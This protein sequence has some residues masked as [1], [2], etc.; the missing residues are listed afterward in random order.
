MEQKW[1]WEKEKVRVE[2]TEESEGRAACGLGILYKR[3]INK[4]KE[5]K[6]KVIWLLPL[7]AVSLLKVL[8]KIEMGNS[9]PFSPILI[10]HSYTKDH[11][12]GFHFQRSVYKSFPQVV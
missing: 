5:K 1:K 11:K 7:Q 10:K 4:E 8:V 12:C 9:E 2:R 6:S 3:R